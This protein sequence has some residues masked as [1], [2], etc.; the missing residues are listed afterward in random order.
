MNYNIRIQIGISSIYKFPK[1]VPA[2]TFIT[3]NSGV[4]LKVSST[5][6]LIFEIEAKKVVGKQLYTF[7]DEKSQKAISLVLKN[8]T[9][10]MLV[11]TSNQKMVY[12]HNSGI[13]VNGKRIIV[14]R[15]ITKLSENQQKAELRYAILEAFAWSATR[16][17]ALN[18]IIKL[19]SNKFKWYGGIVWLLND[20]NA[21]NILTFWSKKSRKS[22]LIISDLIQNNDYQKDLTQKIRTYKITKKNKIKIYSLPIVFENKTIGILEFVGSG[23]SIISDLFKSTIT[24]LKQQLGQFIV[25]KE[26]VAQLKSNEENYRTLVELAPDIIYSKDLRGRIKAIN[27][28]VTSITNLNTKDLLGRPLTVL[29]DASEREEVEEQL[30]KETNKIVTKPVEAR[31]FSQKGKYIVGEIRERPK[32]IN[33][34][35]TMRLGII[36]DI[37]Q[38]KLLEKQK[39]MW[40]GISTHELKTPLTTIKAYTQLLL[41]SKLSENEQNYLKT[42]NAL[43]NKMTNLI[44]DLLDAAQINSGT[45]TIKKDKVSITNLL[46]TLARNSQ[47]AFNTHTIVLDKTVEISLIC[48]KERVGQAISNLVSNAVKYSKPKTKI[49][50]GLQLLQNNAVISVK[51]FGIGIPKK[52]LS[53]V[54]NVFYRAGNYEERSISGLGLGLF[55]AQYIVQK[56]NGKI[57][58]ESEENIGSTFYISLPLS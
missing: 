27:S 49:I 33:K 5:V 31:L 53:N 42:I 44:N 21:F 1:T 57:W 58:V 34:K 52:N 8:N 22:E 12:V 4:V 48:D 25:T 18:Q 16:R 2:A 51:D 15:E 36:R 17:E 28:A 54:F 35:V 32:I 20:E 29:V 19:V 41:K 45:L 23:S 7:F 50:L 9:R 55:I 30:S 39:D 37:T 13:E 26:A 6:K 40:V 38:R 56:H 10:A 3:S 47:I 14:I 11:H 43:T 46:E 24:L